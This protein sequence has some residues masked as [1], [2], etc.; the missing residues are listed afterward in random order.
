M[1]FIYVCD[2]HGDTGKYE[3]IF[4]IC[5]TNN[6][7]NI[8]LGRRLITQKSSKKSANSKR[9]YFQLLARIF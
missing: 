6:I 4:E 1:K 9:I 3:K 2:I 5:K 7:N 8:V